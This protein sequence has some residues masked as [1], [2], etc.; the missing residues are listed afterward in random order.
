MT[1][2]IARPPW[3]RGPAMTNQLPEPTD[4]DLDKLSAEIEAEIF[5]PTPDFSDPLEDLYAEATAARKLRKPQRSADPSLRDALDAA[6]KKMKELYSNPENWTRTRGL[7]LI[8]AAT[9]TAIGNYSEYR[10]CKVPATRK[11]IREHSPILIDGQEIVSGFL[12]TELE[13]KVRGISWDAEQ[14]VTVNVLLDEIQAE[15]PAVLIKACTI[16]CSVVRAELAA[17]TQF[18]T[19]SGNI[20]LKLPAGTDIWAVCSTDTKAAIRKGVL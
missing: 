3:P 8:D 20:I 2:Q 9:Q 18:A 6:A 1:S 10:H 5:S 7:L 13:R 14:Q 16:L 4:S 15:A 11:L 17:D 12:G 19:A